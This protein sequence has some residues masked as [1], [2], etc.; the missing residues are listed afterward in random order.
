MHW[1]ITSVRHHA[2][3]AD[4]ARP[5]IAT[6]RERAPAGEPEPKKEKRAEQTNLDLPYH[7]IPTS[8]TID[9]AF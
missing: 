4:V 5:Q 3:L 8:G 1:K 6:E 2:V 9:S 7:G